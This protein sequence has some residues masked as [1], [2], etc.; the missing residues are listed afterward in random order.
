MDHSVNSK[1]AARNNW[2]IEDIRNQSTAAEIVVFA[3]GSEAHPRCGF[4]ARA[5]DV[6]KDS[7][8]SYKI[9][10]VKSNPA[11]G[12]ALR[13]FSGRRELPVMF[14]NGKLVP[15]SDSLNHPLDSSELQ[16]RVSN[17]YNKE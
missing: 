15:C 11:I 1:F 14:V 17:I 16:D 3:K 12:P 5:I 10:D 2:T 6:V 8:R 7:G 4:S 13:S 9:I